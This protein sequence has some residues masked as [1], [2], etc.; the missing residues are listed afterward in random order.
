MFHS[1]GR[2]IDVA[3]AL[4]KCASCGQPLPVQLDVAAAPAQ[5]C[6]GCARPVRLGGARAPRP[7]EKLNA[8]LAEA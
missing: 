7:A 5:L 8:G 2:R 3:S 6:A 4:K 1:F